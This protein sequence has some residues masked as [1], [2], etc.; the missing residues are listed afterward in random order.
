MNRNSDLWSDH[1]PE[2]RHSA[3][4]R[5][6]PPHQTLKEGW[7]C[8]RNH[9]FPF[10]PPKWGLSVVNLISVQKSITQAKLFLGEYFVPPV[11]KWHIYSGSRRDAGLRRALHK[12]QHTAWLLEWLSLH[13]VNS[14]LFR[15]KKEAADRE[16][17]LHFKQKKKKKKKDAFA[18]LF[19]A[20]NARWWQKI[21]QWRVPPVATRGQH[22]QPARKKRGV[23]YST[24]AVM[25]WKW[26]ERRHR[27]AT[28]W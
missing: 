16:R 23:C 26:L 27:F 21:C 17:S 24:L 15:F 12:T 13:F 28:N 25:G 4:Q 18:W 1:Q 3:A 8:V 9:T 19:V 10:S 14:I 2:W 20:R 11:R 6:F 7:R 5:K 22:G